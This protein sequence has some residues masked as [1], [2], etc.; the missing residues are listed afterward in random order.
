MLY[1]PLMRIVKYSLGEMQANCYMLIEGSE[2]IIIDPADEASFLLEE[3]QR[4]N[5]KLC[6]LIAT[7]GHFDHVMAAGEIQLSYAVPLY[8]HEKDMF[9]IKRVRETAE[10]FL[11]YRPVVIEPTLMQ[12]LT[13]GACTVSRFTFRVIH[14]PGH[15]PGGCCLCFEKENSVFTGDTL[16]KGTV[17]RF[18]FSYS[19][20]KALEKSVRT[21]L[22][23]PGETLVYSGHGEQ[24]FITAEQDTFDVKF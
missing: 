10:Y 8:I 11:G 3:I 4:R 23:L 18:D 7:H 21:I 15:T 2:C 12:P 20:K 24:T 17:G 13:P 22:R 1:N 19:D 5:L 6:A 16:F 9:L 14:T